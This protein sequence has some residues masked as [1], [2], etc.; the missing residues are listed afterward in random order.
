MIDFVVAQPPTPVVEFSSVLTS[1]DVNHQDGRLLLEDDNAALA[2][3]FLPQGSPVDV[4]ISKAGSTQPLAIQPLAIGNKQGVF[5]RLGVRGAVSEFKFTKPGKYTATYR[6]GGRPMTIIP[7]SVEIE[8]NND[9][10]DPKSFVYLNGPWE[11]WAYLFAS[12]EKGS[13]ANPEAHFWVRKKSFLTNPEADRYTAEIRR[14][15]DVLAI[16]EAGS[17]NSRKWQFMRLRFKQPESKGGGPIQMSEIASRD[18]DYQ[19]LIF[20]NGD[21]FA[22]YPLQI[23]QGQIVMHP[24]SQTQHQP[25]TEYIVPRFPGLLGTLG[26]DSAGHAFWMKRQPINGESS[27]QSNV[28][29][30]PSKDDLARW[31]WLPRSIDPNREFDLKVTAISTRNDTHLAA[32]EDLIVFGTGFPRGV[33]YMNVGDDRSREIP[34]GETYNSKV[35]GVCGTKIILVKDKQIVIFDTRSKTLTPIPNTDVALYSP[36]MLTFD[37]NGFLVATINDVAQV[38]DKTVLKVIDVSGDTPAIIPINNAAYTHRDVTSVSVDAK[39]GGVA[40]SSSSKKLLSVAR[41]VPNGKQFLFS[42]DTYRGVGPQKIYLEDEWLTYPDSD[43]KVRL[44]KLDEP[45]KA[46]TDQAFPRVGN[47]F[48]VRKGRLVVATNDQ[49]VGSRYAFAVGDLDDPP[50]LANGTG[51]PIPGTSAGLGMGGSAAIAVDK[52]VFVAGTAG[53]STGVG[54]RLQLFD[55]DSGWIPIIGPSGKPLPASEVVTSMGLLAFK[56]LNKS[57]NPVIGYATYGQRVDYR[58]SSQPDA[59]QR[60]ALQSQNAAD[61]EMAHS[62]AADTK[63]PSEELS[64]IDEAFLA[65]VLKN[66]ELIFNA[67]KNVMSEAEAKQKILESTTKTLNDSGKAHLTETYR[68]RSKLSD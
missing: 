41:I 66:E 52:T 12:V 6:A 65:E 36:S 34:D 48:F 33:A 47:G 60:D 57:R 18:D 35:F 19:I 38:T 43:W 10:F 67:Y 63:A 45:P 40:V 46:V 4:V 29:K 58:P 8:T 55:D 20:R 61:R 14:E 1:L 32:G 31:E 5:N 11:D 25:R 49:K 54:E 51:A 24:R 15:G 17:S 27:S 3:V 21:R 68:R 2:S 9:Q 30:V 59:D 62:T 26:S 56:T 44:L 28:A 22:S 23:R 53:D 37:T 16:S 42:V 64:E 50:I 7:F 13:A 39:S